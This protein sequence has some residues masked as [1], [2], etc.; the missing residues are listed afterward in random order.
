MP[1][2]LVLAAKVAAATPLILK[3]SRRFSFEL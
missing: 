1:R 2:P 3:K